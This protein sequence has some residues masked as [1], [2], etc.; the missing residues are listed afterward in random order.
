[1]SRC[2]SGQVAT[3]S[4]TVSR[5]V[6]PMK[7]LTGRII[8]FAVT[9]LTTLA[10]LEI[11]LHFFGEDIVGEPITGNEYVFSRF[12]PE[13]GWSNASNVSGTLVRSEFSH[14]LR[15]NRYGMRGRDVSLTKPSGLSRIAVLGDSFAWGWGVEE[16]EL[17][18]TIIEQKIPN[19]E[20]LNFAVPGYGP[21][22]YYL[23]TDKV[24]SFN[25][26]VVVIV[27]CLANDFSDNVYS[28]GYGHYRPFAHL[29]EKGE[30][31]IDGYPI[32]NVKAPSNQ[33]FGE[34]LLRRVHDR[35]YLLRLLG[36]PL[37]QLTKFT[38]KLAMGKQKGPPGSVSEYDFFYRPDAP[39]VQ[40]VI[41][42]N[43]KLLEKIVSAY[44]TRGVPIF[45]V[46]APG[47]CELGDCFPDRP[48]DATRKALA[49]S[50]SGLPITLIDPSPGFNLNDFWSKDSHWRASGHRKI[51]AALIPDLD[52]ILKQRHPMTRSE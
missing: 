23:Q 35:L 26:D 11:G 49:L 39:E 24:L 25:P 52:R 41:R 30:V 31:V 9:V 32:R 2:D 38:S 51:A 5:T 34:S 8:L 13:L 36:R 40:W 37:R 20:V 42:V 7:D 48:S 10:A 46:A 12:D 21:V 16:S 15:F 29:D 50:L 14:Q 45:V 47:K 33:F 27:F 3:L 44:H 6:P 43:T 19:T 18:T 28:V 1:M 22:Q 17:F 4:R